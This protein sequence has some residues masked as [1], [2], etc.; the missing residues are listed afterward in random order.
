MSFEEFQGS[1]LPL[2]AEKKASQAPAHQAAPA[3]QL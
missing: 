3:L 2:I 1:A